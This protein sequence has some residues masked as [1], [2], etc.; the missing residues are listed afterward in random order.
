VWPAAVLESQGI[1]AK[2][3]L[4]KALAMKDRPTFAAALA[5]AEAEAAAA[6]EGP[7]VEEPA[8]EAPTE[9]PAIEEPAAP[10]PAGEYEP[11]PF[12]Q[13]ESDAWAALLKK[14]KRGQL[15][16]EE[17]AQAKE[18]TRRAAENAYLGYLNSKSDEQLLMALESNRSPS[19]KSRQLKLPVIYRNEQQILYVMR[20]RGLE[21]PPPPPP[22]VIAFRSGN[23]AAVTDLK[24]FID[25]GQDVG[26]T[27]LGMT[28]PVRERIV[29]RCR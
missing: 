21:A 8:A 29:R 14:E 25:A 18:F 5:E 12:T 6:G 26:V 28:G 20:Q 23:Q 24:G 11:E 2:E 22:Q 16:D 7:E 13:E 3:A 17:K 27:A 15:T 4:T 9:P 19:N 1:P 10:A